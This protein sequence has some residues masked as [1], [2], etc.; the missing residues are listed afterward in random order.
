MHPF[1]H[2]GK[3]RKRFGV[4]ILE[5]VTASSFSENFVESEAWCTPGLGKLL[6]FIL[7]ESY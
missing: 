6:Q 7:G 1:P 5:P 3:Q 2:V 4:M